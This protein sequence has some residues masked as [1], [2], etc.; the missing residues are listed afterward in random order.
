L[1]TF[2]VEQSR[3]WFGLAG[4]GNFAGHLDQAGETGDFASVGSDDSKPRGIFPFY[5]PGLASFLGQ[6]PLSFDAITLP[7]SA[8]PIN[9]QI[10]PEAG[11][12]CRVMYAADGSVESLVPT[13]IGAFNDCS[14]RRAGAKK[15][16]EKK[17]PLALA[18]EAALVAL[19]RPLDP[20]L[21]VM[22]VCHRDGA[23]D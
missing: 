14:I 15:I 17:T 12:I 4:A 1:I 18:E 7:I 6:F 22:S 21:S 10:E 5:G 19:G 2:D 20:C 9:L 16:S 23:I 11:V 13:A 3:E 8:V